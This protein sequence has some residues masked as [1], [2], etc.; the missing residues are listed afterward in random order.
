M[1]GVITEIAAECGVSE[2]AV[3]AWCRR[4]HVAKDAKG[5]FAISESQ[6]SA[7]YQHYL[8]VERK[9]VSQPAKASCETCETALIAML[10]GELDRKSEQLAVK[11][12]QIEELN[13]R[14]AEVSSA[15]VCGQ[16]HRQHIVADDHRQNH[17]FVA[18]RLVDQRANIHLV[19]QRPIEHHAPCSHKERFAPQLF[20]HRSRLPRPFVGRQ[21]RFELPHRMA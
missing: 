20:G 1:A 15:L 17:A 8:G 18:Q 4:N 3:R 21:S 5:S 14:L 9:Q 11:D 6:K 16:F 12:K 13:A 7:I 10:Q 19:G 2:Q